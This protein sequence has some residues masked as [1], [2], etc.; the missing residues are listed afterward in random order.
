MMLLLAFFI[1][2]VP[3][4]AIAIVQ[5]LL[6]QWKPIARAVPSL[7]EEHPLSRLDGMTLYDRSH[8]LEVGIENIESLAHHNI[9]DIMLWTRIP[10]ARLVDLVDQAI[11]Y[12]HLRGPVLATRQGGDTDEARRLLARHGIPDRNRPRA[13]IRAC[14]QSVTDRGRAAHRAGG[15]PRPSGSSPAGRA[16]CAQRRRVDDPRAQ[17]A[18]ADVLRRAGAL[19]GGVPPTGVEDEGSS[20]HARRSRRQG[21]GRGRNSS[22][23]HRPDRLGTRR[24][25]DGD[26]GVTGSFPAWLVGFSWPVRRRR[27]ERDLR[28]RGRCPA[29]YP[30]REFSK[31]RHPRLWGL[32]RTCVVLS[33]SGRV[34]DFTGPTFRVGRAHFGCEVAAVD[35][36]R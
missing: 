21:R 36:A 33:G 11:L 34:S 1:G 2:I 32:R 4:T 9:V 35:W 7:G 17:L 12:L 29:A 6:Q 8:L 16:G 30:F 25:T 27:R 28:T 5:D 10:T 13:F 3:E 31:E 26:R 22:R 19:G 20:T 24:A 23:A 14:C 18:G 15:R